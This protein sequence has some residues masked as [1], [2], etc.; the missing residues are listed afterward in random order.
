MQLIEEKSIVIAWKKAK[1]AI[2]R[3]GLEVLDDN[4][5]LLE[6]LD[7]F[8]II[9][10][11]ERSDQETEVQDIEMKKWMLSNFKDIKNV[12]ISLGGIL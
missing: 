5:V 1:E 12:S 9:H 4:E 2:I 3:E 11:P 8:L 6:L 10:Q 7:L